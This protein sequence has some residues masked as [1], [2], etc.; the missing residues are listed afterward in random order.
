LSD[1]NIINDKQSAYEWVFFFKEKLREAQRLMRQ[2]KKIRNERKNFARKIVS[3]Q[4]V[5]LC[6]TIAL[7][8]LP[9][10]PLEY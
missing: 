1:F 9:L 4:L 10:V 6:V 8:L 3:L 7:L 2:L 5:I